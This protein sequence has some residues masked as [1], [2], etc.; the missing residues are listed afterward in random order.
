MFLILLSEQSKL[1]CVRLAP[2]AG[3]PQAWRKPCGFFSGA[4]IILC[5]NGCCKP[6][7]GRFET[8]VSR[9][10]KNRFKIWKVYGM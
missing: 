1:R 10:W 4:S 5:P 2:A 9:F 7:P 8:V 6:V 3:L